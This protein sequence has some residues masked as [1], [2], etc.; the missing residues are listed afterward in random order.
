MADNRKSH[1]PIENLGVPT[2]GYCVWVNRGK[3]CI[4]LKKLS[5]SFK[6]IRHGQF[7]QFPCI[8]YLPSVQ[9]FTLFFY[10]V[11][12]F[13]FYLS[14]DTFP[15]THVHTGIA[16]PLLTPNSFW[17]GRRGVLKTVKKIVWR[18]AALLLTILYTYSQ[19]D[20]EPVKNPC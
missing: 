11:F 5:G 3:S 2:Y 16:T 15:G 20:S 8:S 14:F 10:F 4:L 6:A 12:V 13:V 18:V 9:F 19:L 1:H 7:Q 17:N